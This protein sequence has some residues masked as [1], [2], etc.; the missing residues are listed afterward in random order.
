MV[1]YREILYIFRYHQFD[2]AILK[3]KWFR[4]H[5]LDFKISQNMEFIIVEWLPIHVCLK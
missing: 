4:Y 5:K 1:L 2:I 3:I